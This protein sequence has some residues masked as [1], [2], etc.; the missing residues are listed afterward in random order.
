MIDVHSWSTGNARK[1]YIMLEET[2]LPYRVHPVNIS[3]GDQ[4]KPE[5]L[6]ISPNNKIP[7]IVDQDGPGGKPYALFETGA[8]LMYLAHK[9][10]RFLPADPAGRYSTIQWLMWQM[11]GLGPMFGQAGHFVGREDKPGMARGRA[12]FVAEAERLMRVLD[13][14]LAES[15]YVAGP[16]YTIADIAIYPWCQDAGKRGLRDE[17]YPNFMRWFGAVGAR[18]AARKADEVAE[19]VRK[20]L[21]AA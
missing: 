19:R 4:F 8:I 3:K 6:K 10:G 16:D 9:T 7:A 21:A 1:V 5:F 2:G 13:A 14:R 15:E 18:P 17:D 11:S 20:G 12:M